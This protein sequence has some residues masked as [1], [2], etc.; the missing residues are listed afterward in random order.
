M[1]DF[2]KPGRSTAHGVNGMAATSHPL[3][4][5]A[6]I[7]M[8][9]AGGNA[10]DA[11][12]AAAA[13][14]AVVE[15]Q[16]T[17]IGGDCFVLFAPGGG[18]EVIALNGSGPA[19]QAATVDWF[20]ERGIDRIGMR[21]PHAV[22][23]PGA[24]DAWTRLLADHG[25]KSIEEVLRPA[26]HCAAEGYVVHPRVAHDWER[27]V[28]SLRADPTAARTFLSQ[29]RAPRAGDIHRQPELA[30]TLEGIARHGRDGFYQ[31]PVAE[32]IVTY[33]RRLGGPHTLDDFARYRSE[34]V[35]P[36]RANY[37]G[38]DVFQCPPNGQG[39]GVLIM[40]SILAGFDLGNLDPIGAPR[41]HLQAEATRLA[42][43]IMDRE[44]GDPAQVNVPVDE[45]LS[46]GNIDSLRARIRMDSAIPDLPGS[47][48]GHSDTIYLSV[49][50]RDRNAVSFI[51]SLYFSFGS[52]LVG[53]ASGVVLQNRGGGFV[54]QPGH[55]NCI[56]PGKRPRHTIIPG[57]ATRD[58]RPVM[59]FGVM[60]GTYQPVGQVQVLTNIVDYAMDPQEAIDMPR[61]MHHA[62][63]YGLERGFAGGVAEEL[64][65]LGHE[66]AWVD[67]PWGG[68][69]AIWIDWENGTLVGGSDPRKDG[70]ALGY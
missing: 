11:A 38:L 49:V 55:P 29:G 67:E 15:P 42:Y 41:L 3:A 50:D 28:D 30:A 63:V 37:R 18:G 51:N 66:V 1:R 24:V 4:T 13:V 12:I 43:A 44:L 31:G 33:L 70:F 22:T 53:P 10:I 40:L 46:P 20:L 47:T 32:D 34:Y 7:D 6:A 62:G 39:I 56:A 59:T 26:I 14:Q 57:M 2:Q 35:T 25:T 23:V 21:G 54:L 60:G 8:L 36:I 27:S 17:G 69:Q 65:R 58:G 64:R 68:G 61:G 52:G 16:S 9:R 19:P 45:I 48:F 5:L